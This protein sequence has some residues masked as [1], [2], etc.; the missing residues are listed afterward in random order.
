MDTTYLVSCQLELSSVISPIE[1]T[2]GICDY[3]KDLELTEDEIYQVDCLEILGSLYGITERGL[4][5]V[6]PQVDTNEDDRI[7]L[8]EARM[9]LAR[10]KVFQRKDDDYQTEDQTTKK[11]CTKLECTEDC[12]KVCSGKNPR[13]I[14]RSCKSHSF[15]GWDNNNNNNSFCVSTEKIS[16]TNCE[17]PCTNRNSVEKKV[18]V[19]QTLD[20][21]IVTGIG[22]VG[23]LNKFNPAWLTCCNLKGIEGLGCPDQSIRTTNPVLKH[24]RY[25]CPYVTMH[26]DKYPKCVCKTRFKGERCD[27]C[28]GGLIGSECDSCKLGYYEID[29]YPIYL[30]IKPI[31][32]R[33]IPGKDN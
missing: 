4:D 28:I 12:N 32:H 13:C 23:D 33:C 10:A 30:S 6:L 20:R 8:E 14:Y 29:I 16:H 2:F 22:S 15:E 21:Y 25:Y 11:P 26:K 9:A 19:N 3:D 27:Q 7:S 5:E 1:S 17:F 18:P 31:S 24:S